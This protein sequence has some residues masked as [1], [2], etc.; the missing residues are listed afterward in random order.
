MVS[1]RPNNKLKIIARDQSYDSVE[2]ELLY[3]EVERFN[4]T[5]LNLKTKK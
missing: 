4:K 5:F 3:L 1:D 2:V